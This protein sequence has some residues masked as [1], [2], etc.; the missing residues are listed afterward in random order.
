MIRDTPVSPN[1]R[2]V[3][4]HSSSPSSSSESSYPEVDTT[5]RDTYEGLQV[6]PNGP[7][8]QPTT[9]DDDI[10]HKWW[11]IGGSSE[12]Q[13]RPG[14]DDAGLIAVEQ[15]RTGKPKRERICGLK[16]RTFFI[17]AAIVG[18]L[19]VCAAVGG[20]VG[21]AMAARKGKDDNGG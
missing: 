6:D 9:S 4:L 10:K 19:V 13:I 15:T 1:H 17:V 21:G 2:P 11:H 12:K 5:S 16:R 8:P 14:S 18:I 3:L 7:Y 20:G